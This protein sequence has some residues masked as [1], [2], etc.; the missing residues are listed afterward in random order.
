MFD[1][2][3]K[4]KAFP[5]WN[6]L[7]DPRSCLLPFLFD[8]PIRLRL[9]KIA[10]ISDIKQAF[11]HTQ[12]DTE[13]RDFLRFLWDNDIRTASLPSVL[14]FTRLVFGLISSPFIW[15]ATVKF[16]LFQYLRKGK[17]KWVIEK[18][19]QDLN[20]DESTASFDDV[21]DAY[22][23]YETPIPCLQRGNSDLGKWITKKWK[24]AASH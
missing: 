24:L 3:A 18:F 14:C 21:N 9:G 16:H 22:Y 15:N 19:L 5:S 1:A 13:Q 10:L 20:V 12:I 4:Y 11:L 17:L 8:M 6:E 7:L 2:S 23:F